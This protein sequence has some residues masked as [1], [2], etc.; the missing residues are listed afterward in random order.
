MQYMFLP[1]NKKSEHFSYSC[2]FDLSRCVPERYIEWEIRFDR[3]NNLKYK[4]EAQRKQLN[5]LGG[6]TDGIFR[7]R[8][9]FRFAWREDELGQVEIMC[10]FKI[11]GKTLPVPELVY[12]Y[13]IAV[14]GKG[15]RHNFRI[16]GLKDKIVFQHILDDHAISTYIDY[17]WKS[18]FSWVLDP[19]LG[20]EE[21]YDQTVTLYSKIIKA[22]QKILTIFDYG[23][24]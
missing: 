16:Y 3:R 22:S 15:S 17:K 8:N 1:G 13:R 11:K 20:N 4:N 12:K 6:F 14:I 18:R 5:L 9:E 23:H 10:Y 7:H 21:T 2:M 19:V 24:D